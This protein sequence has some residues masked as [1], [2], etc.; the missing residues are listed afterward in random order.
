LD[1]DIRK[2]GP[3]A[4]EAFTYHGGA[5]AVA[6][7]LRPAAPRPWIDLST[8]VNPHAYPIGDIAPEAWA[9]LPEREAL[10]RLE[11]TAAWLYGAASDETVAASGAQALIQVLASL[12]PARRVGALG[13]TYSG[14]ADAWR[15]AR[16]EVTIVASLRELESFDVAIVVNPNN[17]DG[18]IVARGALI[19]LAERLARRGGRLIVDEAFADFDG[20]SESLGPA[21][22][23]RHAIVLRSFGKTYGLAGL[24]LGFA[25]AP[26]E[27]AA[28]LRDALGPWPVSGPAIAIGS[29][30]LADGRWLLAMA[31]RLAKD[32]ARLDAL[33]IASGWQIVGGTRL[34]RLA[35]HAGASAIFARLLTHGVLARPFAEA[36]DRLRF[37][38]PSEET[39]WR[40]LEAA[41]V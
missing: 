18:R 41:L 11:R 6:M 5:L 30:A 3:S 14:H 29:E 39:Q 34:F 23:T 19:D 22:P 4:Q 38:L 27:L 37:G 12:L 15:A 28:A 2:D 20:A 10:A 40:R 8:G 24:R 26:T 33:L 32:A 31:A 7:G 16:A 25:I 1:N 36:P 35:A 9:R 17:P 21:A 13:P